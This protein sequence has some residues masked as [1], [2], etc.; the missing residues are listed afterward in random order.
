MFEKLKK[1]ITSFVDKASTQELSPEKVSSN[2]NEF[3]TRLLENDVALVVTD[4]ITEDIGRRID[5]MRVKIFEDKKKIVE[6]AVEGA[7]I[8]ILT[9]VKNIDLLESAAEKRKERKPLTI[10]FAGINGTG[11]TTTLCK[12]T[13]LFVDSGFSVILACSDTYR[14]GA[15]EQLEEHA[16]RLNVKMIKHE[17]GSDAAS[18][19]FDAVAHAEA[20]G[21]NVVMIDTAGRMETNQNLME[22]MYKIV[23]VIKP[24]L[25][26]FIGDALTGNDAVMQAEE[27]NKYIQI[28]ASILTKMDADAKGG[29]AISISSITGKPIIYFGQG[30]EYTDLKPFNPEFFV[31]QL[32]GKS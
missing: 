27:F 5:G 7:L 9:K 31:K 3:K 13:K 4:K 15:I 24:D 23:R 6:E 12:L 29:A 28:D 10:V 26:I 11:K 8:D 20:K 21:F 1:S 17:Y 32:L 16:R 18:V 30:Q 14:A 19:A 22:E 2:L 25:T